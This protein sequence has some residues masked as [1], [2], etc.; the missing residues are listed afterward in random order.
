MSHMIW[1]AVFAL[2]FHPPVELCKW[3]WS[4][5]YLIWL[6]GRAGL[7]GTYVRSDKHAQR[8]LERTFKAL[9]P[10]DELLIV[11]RTNHGLLRHNYRLFVHALAK[12]A[13]IKML[14][15]DRGALSG[16][17]AHSNVDLRSLGINDAHWELSKDLKDVEL[18]L[19]ELRRECERTAC[20]GSMLVYRSTVVVQSSVVIHV[21]KNQ[22][23]TM[24]LTYDFSFGK[25]RKF[26]QYYE[27]KHS[28]DKVEVDFCNSLREFYQQMFT[29]AADRSKLDHELSYQAKNQVIDQNGIEVVAEELQKYIDSH[30]QSEPVR[31]NGLT[32]MVPAIPPIFEAIRLGNQAPPPLSVQLEL[33]NKCTTACSH[34]YRFEGSASTNQD[35]RLDTA[36]DLLSQL[37]AFGV[38]TVT[39]SGGE[40]TKHHDFSQLLL[41]AYTE[42]L[43]VGVIS[44]GVGLSSAAV[45]A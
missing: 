31:Q 10:G 29:P 41:H 35:I 22:G 45:A 23:K 8:L 37:G 30:P 9:M 39:F 1:A 43:L 44:N 7:K 26:I 27:R 5:A 11:G 36:K 40:P 19:T 4:A 17:G 15:L 25:E 42:G 2:V 21:P 6:A 13:V 20:T 34:C 28:E 12:G 24:H 38:R 16:I 18:N 14:I 3:I 32:R 33:T